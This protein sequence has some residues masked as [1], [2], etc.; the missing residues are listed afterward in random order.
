MNK[1]KH[2]RTRNKWKY[3]TWQKLVMKMCDCNDFPKPNNHKF[4]NSRLFS[5]I[6][7]LKD[8]NSSPMND[9]TIKKAS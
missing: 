8:R 6:F 9:F 1:H 7:N 3:S 2:I 5:R 4:E